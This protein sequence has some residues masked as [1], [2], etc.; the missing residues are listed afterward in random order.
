MEKQ[1]KLYYFLVYYSFNKD[2][3]FGFGSI[4]IGTNKPLFKNEDISDLV[5]EQDKT[6][7]SL[8]LTGFNELS[9]EQYLIYIGEK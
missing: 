3:A 8:T 2:N 4:A 9:E 1:K 5:I 6:I 7:K